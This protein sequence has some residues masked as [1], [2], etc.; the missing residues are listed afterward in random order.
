[1][2][3]EAGDTM[4]LVRSRD[5][6]SATDRHVCPERVERGR[7]DG[8]GGSGRES[9]ERSVETASKGEFGGRDSRGWSGRGEWK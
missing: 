1:M 5:A 7:A 2:E 9:L 6:A 3:S 8:D 4:T